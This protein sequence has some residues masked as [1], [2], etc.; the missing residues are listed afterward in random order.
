MGMTAPHYS[1]DPASDRPKFKQIADQIREQILSGHLDAG[2][3]LPGEGDIAA[4]CGVAIGTVKQALTSLRAEGLVSS[5]RGRRWT[6]L[7]YRTDM[8]RRYLSGQRNYGLAQPGAEA[9]NIG[10]TPGVVDVHAESAEAVQTTFAAE[11]GVT[12]A[13]FASGLDRVYRRI[14]A[15]ER[16]AR[17]LKLNPGAQVFERRWI[18]RI[19]GVVIRVAWSYLDAAKFENTIMTDMAEPPWPGGT[20]AQLDALGHRVRKVREYPGLATATGELAELLGVAE[21]TRLLRRWRTHYVGGIGSNA[22][23]AVETA[24]HVF[25]SPDVELSYDV[26][27]YP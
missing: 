7:P 20:I 12:W 18:H 23:F 9:A 14:P 8:A 10:G 1:I 3:Q 17:E 19:D 11:H 25:A 5:E 2:A 21:G 4:A 24:Y 22:P 16:V 26:V 27:L 6:V 13:E 15:P